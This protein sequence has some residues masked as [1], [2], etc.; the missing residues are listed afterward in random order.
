M[1]EFDETIALNYKP[2]GTPCLATGIPKTMG[3]QGVP[4]NMRYSDFFTLFI[5]ALLKKKIGLA[6]IFE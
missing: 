1:P 5:Y 4:E 6:E 2:F 3:I